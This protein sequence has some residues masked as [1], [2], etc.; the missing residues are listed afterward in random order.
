LLV[1]L[2]K[3]GLTLYKN[4][5]LSKSDTQLF[6]EIA[7]THVTSSVASM[8]NVFAD[9]VQERLRR[10]EELVED[11]G[12]DVNFCKFSLVTGELY[13]KYRLISVC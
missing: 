4:L 5:E 6:K 10:L 9:F 11:Y 7:S 8:N 13:M 3:F 2:L 1:E 12:F